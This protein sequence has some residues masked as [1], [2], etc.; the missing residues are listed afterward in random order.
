MNEQKP[1]HEIARKLDNI[2]EMLR[3]TTRKNFR[4]GQKVRMTDHAIKRGLQGRAKAQYGKVVAVKPDH[5][6]VKVQRN[7]LKTAD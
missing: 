7:G 3:F 4:V 6:R 2:E 1:I 5:L